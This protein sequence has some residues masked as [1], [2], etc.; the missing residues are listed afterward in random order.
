MGEESTN[1]KRILEDH[2]SFMGSFQSNTIMKPKLEYVRNFEIKPA[3]RHLIQANQFNGRVHESPYDHLSTFNDICNTMKINN[4]SDDALKWCLFPFSLTSDTISQLRSF[5]PNSL[6]S[7]EDVAAMFLHRYF[8]KSKTFKGKPT[9]SSFQQQHDEALI[10]AWEWYQSLLQQMQTHG[11]DRV[12]QINIFL[13]GLQAQSKLML[14]AA[15]KGNIVLK[16]PEK[17]SE[18]IENI[19]YNDY[20]FQ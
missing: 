16:T 8:P 3:P 7:W 12:L 5:P 18:I 1:A 15:T 11:F 17:I 14:D 19:A 4:V 9:I 13:G 2:A 10:E 6:S 20:E